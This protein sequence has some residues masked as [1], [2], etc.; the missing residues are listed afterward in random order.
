[1]RSTSLSSTQRCHR[2]EPPCARSCHVNSGR[3]THVM[4]STERVMGATEHESERCGR[5]ASA[6]FTSTPLLGWL[7]NAPISCAEG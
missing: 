4:R 3:T 2:S 5:L 1:M 7:R 6:A